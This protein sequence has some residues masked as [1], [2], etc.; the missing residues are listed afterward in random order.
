M[1]QNRI[2]KQKL[3]AAGTVALISEPLLI[4]AHTGGVGVI[5][6]LAAAAAT[7]TALVQHSEKNALADAG[8]DEDL[9]SSSPAPAT[10]IKNTNS[11]MYRLL[12]GKSTRA[13]DIDQA[14]PEPTPEYEDEDEDEVSEDPIFKP[15]RADD[16]S[17]VR[18]LTVDEI[19]EHSERNDYKVWVGRSLTDPDHHGVKISFKK[20]HFRF[21]GA[22]QRGKSSMV[23][24]FLDIITQTH[25]TKHVKLALL[26]LENQ[27]SK[28]FA[29]LPHVA[30]VRKNG[31][32][33]KLHARNADEVLSRLLDIVDLMEARYQMTKEQVLKQPVL[34]VYVEEFLALKNEFKSRINRSR[35]KGPEAKDQAIS[36]YSNLVNCIEA[37][38]QRG[39]KARVQLLLCAQVEY[40]DDDFKEALVSVQCGFSFCVRPK[41]ALSAGFTNTE[42]LNKNF[43][44]NKVGQAVVE[45][46]DANDLILAPDFDLEQKLIEYERIHFSDEDEDED[47][48]ERV[49]TT[50]WQDEKNTEPIRKPLVK[51]V[52]GSEYQREHLPE[53]ENI[54]I[55]SQGYSQDEEVSVL[56]AFAELAKTGKVTRTGIRDYLD[57]NS[58]QY[59]RVIMPVCEKHGLCMV[60][61]NKESE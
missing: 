34:L 51:P 6:G 60:S 19:V 18:R 27:T 48:F 15:R 1:K 4:A 30:V 23:A 41:A 7:Y 39:L 50:S 26:D 61:T 45:T 3:L 11:I 38:A 40:S 37:L 59:Q 17:G 13:A 42:L 25:D 20:H 9:S 49:N 43:K 16:T 14:T 47:E 36:D 31:Q 55:H 54:Q 44:D 10:N 8:D 2:D 22:S 28:L 35:T 57:W 56:K 12:N 52:N 58:K 24:A 53:K 29:D 5:C 46:P 21:F 33:I 32:S